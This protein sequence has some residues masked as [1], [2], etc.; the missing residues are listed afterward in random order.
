MP[1]CIAYVIKVT[2]SLTNF[3]YESEKSKKRPLHGMTP[4]TLV[5]YVLPIPGTDCMGYYKEF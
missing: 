1:R 4:L 3:K 2:D 5:G